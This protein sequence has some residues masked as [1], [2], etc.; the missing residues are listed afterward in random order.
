[1]TIITQYKACCDSKNCSNE[2]KSFKD[3]MYGPILIKLGWSTFSNE[4]KQEWFCP[5]CSIFKKFILAAEESL[6]INSSLRKGQAYMNT[7]YNFDK[8]LYIKITKDNTLDPFYIDNKL[9]AFL[10]FV[11]NEWK[12]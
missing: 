5:P 4:M 10:K 9:P 11:E 12:D 8:T 3:P 2:S 7:L 6:R 1:V